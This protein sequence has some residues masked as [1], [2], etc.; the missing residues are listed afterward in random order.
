MTIYL[1]R[2]AYADVQGAVRTAQL[3]GVGMALNTITGQII[4]VSNADY[5]TTSTGVLAVN[6]AFNPLGLQY[7][8]VQ[9]AATLV[10]ATAAGT[11]V[12]IT[13]P[14]PQ[15]SIFMADQETVD[16]SSV[17]GVVAACIGLLCD[18]AGNVVASFLAGYRT[19]Q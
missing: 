4:A 13:I 19:R 7:I 5:V 17:A 3:L 14:A 12:S 2:T 8:S 10:F 11:T 15:T 18:S 16:P 9:D 6:P 1:N